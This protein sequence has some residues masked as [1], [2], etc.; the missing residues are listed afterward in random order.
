M[1]TLT[2]KTITSR[3]GYEIKRVQ[4]RGLGYATVELSN[5]EVLRVAEGSSKVMAGDY[6][7]TIGA[8]RIHY[9]IEEVG[10]SWVVT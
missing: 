1:S 7:V 2:A 6:V 4:H 8:T 10:V 5:D 3:V 9:T